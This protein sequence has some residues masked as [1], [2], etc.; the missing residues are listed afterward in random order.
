MTQSPNER[1]KERER[2]YW[3]QAQ[4]ILE[5]LSSLSDRDGEPSSYLQNIALG[6]SR[7]L[8]LDW[9]VVTFC[10]EENERVMASSLDLGE[11]ENIYLL[12][13]TLTETV[14]KTGNTL[15]VEDAIV[16]SEYGQP[17]EGYRSYLGV[18]L[19]TSR[20][21][22]LGTI[23]SFCIQPRQFTLAEVRTV[24]LFAERAATA[25]DN[26]NL[27]QQ[28]KQFNEILTIEI[29]KRTEELKAA[30]AQIIEQERLAAIGQF[31]STIVHEIRN[32]LTTILMGLTALEKL[33]L[34]E[35][36]RLRLDLAKDEANRLQNLMQEI[37]LYAKP[38]VLQL[39]ELEL[40]TFLEKILVS[41][42]EMPEALERQIDLIT[43]QPSVKIRAD[44]GKLKQVLINLVRNACEAISPGEKVT[45]KVTIANK[46][47]LVCLSIHN[48]GIPIPS[49]LL[50][51]LTQPF[52]S[53]K[54]EGTGLGLAIVRRIV[55]AHGGKLS[56]HSDASS[57]TL[58]SF[59]IPVSEL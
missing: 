54:P 12:H 56:I 8:D 1:E 17:P 41:L 42:R 37:L 27:Y 47:T 48:G 55:E 38:Q 7:L 45:C 59:T 15:C 34:A 4:Q 25:I 36:D 3:E 52:C 51:K 19:R 43:V 18:P 13:G 22:I 57:G 50:P 46:P 6:V 40:N 49:D 53:T 31:A 29:A 44:K 39:E 35:R 9:S 33:N 16:H 21:E 5:I 11:S 28:T 30:Q 58:V 24:E 23:C 10:W 26:Y 2:H 32:P 14:V 20:G